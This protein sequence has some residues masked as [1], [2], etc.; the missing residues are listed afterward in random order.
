[1][2]IHIFIFSVFTI[3]NKK[4]SS[5]SVYEVYNILLAAI[6]ATETEYHPPSSVM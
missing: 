5:H 1:M 6:L 4:L 3:I 2:I